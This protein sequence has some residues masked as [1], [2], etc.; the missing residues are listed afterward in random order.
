MILRAPRLAVPVVLALLACACA[1]PSH[2]LG[3][4]TRGGITDEE[5]IALQR[6]QAEGQQ[7]QGNCLW[8]DDVTRARTSLPCGYLPNAVLATLAWSDDKHALLELGKR[9]EEGRGIAQD[10]DKAEKLYERAAKTT[11]GG[12]AVAT[13]NGYEPI[14]WTS[15]SGLPEAEARL[16]ALRAKR[17]SR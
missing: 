5:R 14:T 2:Y 6:A 9:V 1:V 12:T 13:R 8:F 11:T 7:G 4:P 15:A 10:F 16:A 17:G 3:I